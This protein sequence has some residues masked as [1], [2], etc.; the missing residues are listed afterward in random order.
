MCVEPRL[1]QLVEGAERAQAV[2][3]KRAAEAHGRFVRMRQPDRPG[4]QR[5]QVRI[6]LG[7]HPLERRQAVGRLL[8]RI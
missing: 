4:S 3:R 6:G 2:F 8:Q 7:G 1:D 5:R